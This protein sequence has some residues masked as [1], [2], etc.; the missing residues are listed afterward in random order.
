MGMSPQPYETILTAENLHHRYGSD[1]TLV[2]VSFSLK[3]GTIGCLLGPSGSGKT[4]LL[5]CLAGLESLDKGVITLSGRVIARPGEQV[6][7]HERGIG[8]VFQD[9]ALFPHMT[10]AQN[11]AFGLHQLARTQRPQRVKELLQLVHLEP[12]S[13]AFPS[14]L[15][16]GQQQRVA[17]AR[18]LAPSPQLLLLDEPFSNLDPALRDQL[19]MELKALLRDAG[20]T[21]LIVTHNQDEAFDL[22]DEIGVMDRGRLLQWGRAY[23]LYHRPRSRTV[24]AFLGMGSFLPATINSTGTAILCELGELICHE[25]LAGR[26]FPQHLLPQ[27]YSF[28]LL[29]RPDD[30]I[31]DDHSSLKATVKRV[32]FRG[33]YVIYELELPS[34]RTVFSFT[35]SHHEHHPVGTPIGIRLDVKHTVILEDEWSTVVGPSETKV[36]E[37]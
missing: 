15:S 20:V 2:D 26:L 32:A 14:Q 21:A 29:L 11:I 30:I 7:A 22:A 37:S 36:H 8:V 10:V 31:H 16:G 4:T 12:W 27:S 3:R 34:G 5:R 6:P 23:E 9:Y 1:E 19:K 17:M 35:S 18:A 13:D 25:E 28:T 33:M 24:A